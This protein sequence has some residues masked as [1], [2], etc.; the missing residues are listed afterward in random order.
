MPA[1]KTPSLPREKL[2]DILYR[3]AALSPGEEL[4][5]PAISKQQQSSIIRNLFRELK[6]MSELNPEPASTISITPAFRDSRFWVKLSNSTPPLSTFF[7]KG[8]DGGIK[9]EHLHETKTSNFDT[10]Y[11]GDDFVA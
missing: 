2:I 3:T 1:L 6:L 8:E 11:N 7:I 9:K 4:F 5:I 10:S